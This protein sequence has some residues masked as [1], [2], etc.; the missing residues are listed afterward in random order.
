[1]DHRR[2][3]LGTGVD[4]IVGP[5]LPG[6]PQLVVDQVD[7]GHGGAGDLGVLQGE[8]AQPTDAVDGGA[9]L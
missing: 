8:V 3:V 1:V 7:R 4:G 2:R 5:Q 9:P 6:Q